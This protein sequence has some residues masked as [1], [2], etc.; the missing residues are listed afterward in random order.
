MRQNNR[1]S[2]QTEMSAPAIEG[3][4][5][6]INCDGYYPVCPRCLAELEPNQKFCKECGQKIVW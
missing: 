5:V 3:K 2:E 6:L 1:T 4:K